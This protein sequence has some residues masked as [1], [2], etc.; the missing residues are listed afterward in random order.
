M[1]LNIRSSIIRLI[2]IIRKSKKTLKKL[3]AIIINYYLIINKKNYLYLLIK[4]NNK[5]IE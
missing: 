1:K 5:I 3:V 4:D 2:N